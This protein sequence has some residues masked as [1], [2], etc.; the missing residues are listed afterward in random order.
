MPDDLDQERLD[1]VARAASDA[2]AVVATEASRLAAVEV[3]GTSP[4]RRV[5]VRVT[6]RG[7]ITRLRL[8]DGALQRYDGSAL[9]ELV[10]RTIRDAQRKA[11]EA[12]QRAV[13]ALVPP[14][15][16]ANDEEL[17]RIWRER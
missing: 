1:R 11:R 6:A 5:E 12:Y 4:D 2:M 9:G 15:I 16:A 3:D 8:R 17:D 7:R 14:E 13:E 10:A